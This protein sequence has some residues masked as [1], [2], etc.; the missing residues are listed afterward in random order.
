[1]QR[2]RRKFNAIRNLCKPA[3]LLKQIGVLFIFFLAMV[4]M[5][6]GQERGM[7]RVPQIRYDAI[8]QQAAISA[9]GHPK[10]VALVVAED[11]SRGAGRPNWGR[12]ENYRACGRTWLV[13]SDACNNWALA[14]SSSWLPIRVRAVAG[15]S[16]YAPC[17]AYR[18]S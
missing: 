13:C 12:L 2:E 8:T 7:D 17:L 11:Y 14:K 16:H 3:V 18:E 1:M 4:R 6:D 5:T 15:Q 10:L 9:Q